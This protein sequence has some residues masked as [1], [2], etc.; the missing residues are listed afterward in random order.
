M[1]QYVQKVTPVKARASSHSEVASGEMSIETGWEQIKGVCPL[2]TGQPYSEAHEKYSEDMT[3]LIGTNN[4][5]KTASSEERAV[6][7]KVLKDYIVW[8]YIEDTEYDEERM[9]FSFNIVEYYKSQADLDKAEELLEATETYKPSAIKG[10]E[11]ESTVE[12]VDFHR[13]YPS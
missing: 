7:Q 8:R 3:N 13:P 9:I 1:P 11:N 12:V 5:F 10:S 2:F 4:H 6:F